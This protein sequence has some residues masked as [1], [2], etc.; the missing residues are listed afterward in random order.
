MILTA[1]SQNI[2]IGAHQD[3][4][5]EELVG[6]IRDVDP[7]L[8]LLQEVEWLAGPEQAKAAREGLGMNLVVAPSRQMNPAV[9]WKP[10]V[11]EWLDTDTRY[12]ATDMHH[13]Y[14]SLQLR[15]L[16]LAKEWPVPLVAISTHLTPYSVEAAGQEA[17]LLI[18][19]AYRFGGIGLVGGDINHMPLGD[20]EPD[21]SLI[22]PYNRSSRCHRRKSSTD[23]WCGNRL[24]GEVF[25]DGDMTDVAAHVADSRPDPSLRALTGKGGQLRVDQFHVTPALAP[26]IRDYR[27]VDT[28]ADHYGIVA[29]FDLDQ[30]DLAAIS[31]YT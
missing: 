5:W 14:C 17:Q 27:R 10:G 18:A 23:P 8:L 25:R 30:V 9:A 12:S 3:G 4:R 13:G 28:K 15:P 22:P 7:D 29:T 11:L 16:G 6:A 26:A 1:M 20:E 19:R 21:W 31:T 2:Q 24:V